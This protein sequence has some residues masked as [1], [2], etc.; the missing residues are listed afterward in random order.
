MTFATE[1]TR[2]LREGALSIHA[3]TVQNR[4]LI[5]TF[6][7]HYVWNATSYEESASKKVYLKIKMHHV[8]N[9]KNPIWFAVFAVQTTRYKTD[10]SQLQQKH[11]IF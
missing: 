5:H 3:Y 7:I 4:W 9:D 1:L 10:L 8:L 11:Q 2:C 6:T